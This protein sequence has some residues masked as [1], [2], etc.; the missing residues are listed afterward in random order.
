[1]TVVVAVIEIVA[2]V[3]VE[4]LEVEGLSRYALRR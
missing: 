4:D 1:M 2:V 3:G